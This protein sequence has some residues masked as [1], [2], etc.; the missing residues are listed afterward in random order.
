[1]LYE[2]LGEAPVGAVLDFSHVVASG[3]NE[4]DA[5]HRLDDRIGHMHPRDAVLGDINRSIGCGQVNFPAAIDALTTSGYHGQ[6]QPRAGNPRHVAPRPAGR[7]R[8]GRA[9]HH[10]LLQG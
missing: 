2:A 4:V 3:G 5:I 9:L 10:V 8:P 6:L 7:S 1:M